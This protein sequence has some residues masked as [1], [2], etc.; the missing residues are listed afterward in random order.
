M[1][2]QIA[3]NLLTCCRSD[4][5]K[6]HGFAVHLS[7]HPGSQ[8]GQAGEI[9]ALHQ[10]R[11]PSQ[12]ALTKGMPLG[13]HQTTTNEAIRLPTRVEGVPLQEHPEK[14]VGGVRNAGGPGLPIAHRSNA[15]A[16][17]IG[18]VLPS[19]AGELA[20][21][22]ELG[23]GDGHNPRT[24]GNPAPASAPDRLRHY[25]NINDPDVHGPIFASSPAAWL[26]PV[27]C[28]P[29]GRIE[30]AEIRIGPF[31]SDAILRGPALLLGDAAQI[32]S[33]LGSRSATRG[34]RPRDSRRPRRAYRCWFAQGRTRDAVWH[35]RVM[36]DTEFAMSMR[37]CRRVIPHHLRR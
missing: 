36:D 23:R 37:T 21:L 13:R 6:A 12:I 1:C 16:E 26:I 3:G 35:G 7:L 27:A 15:N 34:V 29:H 33:C 4:K 5:P 17:E 28:G 32:I 20:K 24:T 25:A 31:Q 18:H 14:L 2:I 30:L 8:P 10:K 19:L 9:G 22:P 11:Q